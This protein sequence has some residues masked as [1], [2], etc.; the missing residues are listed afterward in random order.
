MTAYSL[1]A[2]VFKLNHE[3]PLAAA[4]LTSYRAKGLYGWIMIGARDDADA[5]REAKRSYVGARYDDLEIY[6]EGRYVP[7][8]TLPTYG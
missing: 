1:P 3:K 2:I 4:G 6:R 5:L 8:D 7:I